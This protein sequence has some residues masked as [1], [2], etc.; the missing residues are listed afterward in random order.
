MLN[1]EMW[2]VQNPGLGAALIW[3]FGRAFASQTE[4]A[5]PL[6][7]AFFVI[8]LLYNKSTLD[9]IVKTNKGL[10]KI[11]EKLTNDESIATTAQ[12]N[13][14]NMRSLS[15]ESLAIALRAGLVAVRAE[16]ATYRSR[17]TAPP[18]LDGKMPKELMKAAEKLGR[19]AAEVS[20][21]EFCFVFRL[22]L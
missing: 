21:R 12:T 18:I 4:A 7:Y 17:V 6:P 9:V 16:D 14:L 20:L 3:Q 11:E 2:Q 19:W 5:V 22:E 1:K 13:V 15:S 8:P 10:R